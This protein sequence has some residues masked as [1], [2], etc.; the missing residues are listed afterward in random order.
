[1]DKKKDEKR[2]IKNKYNPTPRLE[3]TRLL[4]EPEPKEWK[5]SVRS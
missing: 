4:L 2:N 1:M 3:K 5:K